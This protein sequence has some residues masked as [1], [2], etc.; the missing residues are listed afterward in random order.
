VQP[1][2]LGLLLPAI[3]WA[4]TEFMRMRD[5]VQRGESAVAAVQA[6]AEATKRE[7]TALR[8][9]DQRELRARFEEFTARVARLEVSRERDDG[10]T[11]TMRDAISRLTAVVERLERRL[12][13]TPR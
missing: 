7:A 4:G 8:E 1:V 6:A 13:G 12:D 3:L 10:E 11:R 2:L 9:G 5:A